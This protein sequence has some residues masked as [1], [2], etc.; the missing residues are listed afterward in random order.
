VP[1]GRAICRAVEATRERAPGNVNLGIV[2]LL[3]PLAA[4][5]QGVSLAA[6]IGDVLEALTADDAEMVYR[7]IRLANPGGLGKVAEGDVAEAPTGTLLDAMRLAE[8]RDRVA[9]QYSHAF[10][11]VLQFGMP[12]VVRAA[13][14]GNGWE[15]AVI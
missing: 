4:V 13:E 5:P 2:L 9:Y 8:Q 3:A 12:L 6:G 1:V 11:D 15:Q 14:F 7:A 10:S